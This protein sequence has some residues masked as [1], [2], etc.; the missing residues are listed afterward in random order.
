MQNDIHNSLDSD[1]D[2]YKDGRNPPY[3]LMVRTK[4]VWGWIKSLLNR[5][6]KTNG[7]SSKAQCG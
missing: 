4:A 1:Q 7:S 6:E 3:V 5:K 2:N